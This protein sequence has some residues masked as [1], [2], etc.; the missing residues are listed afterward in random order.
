M[1]VT[2]GEEDSTAAVAADFME[3]EEEGFTAAVAADFM[4]V[5]EEGFAAAVAEDFMEVAEEGFT[6]AVAEDFMEVAEEGFTAAVAE[7]FG[8]ETATDG[9]GD[10]ALGGRIGAGNGDI[11]IPTTTARGITRP[12]LILTRTTVLR[13][14]LR[15]IRI[16]TTGTTILH[17][18]IPTHGPSPTRTDPQDPGDPR[19]R[20]AQPTQTAT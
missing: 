16:L 7:D 2:V 10:L 3:V 17:R 1:E 19:Y 4:E 11:R 20:E 18:Q 8:A 14:I 15:P 12:T 6:A 5:E 13:T 9:A